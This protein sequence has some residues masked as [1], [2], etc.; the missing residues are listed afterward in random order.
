MSPTPLNFRKS[1]FAPPPDQ[2]SR[3]IPEG[4]TL[5]G[6]AFA[7]T[8][9]AVCNATQP[10]DIALQFCKPALRADFSSITNECVHI[11]PV[12]SSTVHT[13]YTLIKL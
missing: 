3:K 4:P 9:F 12:Q 13:Y 1:Q 8:L 5:H 2:I 6:T 11:L 10:D 7:L